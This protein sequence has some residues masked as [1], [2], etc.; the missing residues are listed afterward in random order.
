MNLLVISISH[1]TAP[2]HIR[3]L[4]AFTKKKQAQ[5]IKDIISEG[6]ADECVLISTCNR[7]EFYL[8]N[9]ENKN[10][11]DRFLK[12]LSV[13]ADIRFDICRYIKCYEN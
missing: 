8:A 2:I 4:F 9:N 7:T 6:I 3:Q 12:Y 5:I 13:L 10:I 1:K 11:V